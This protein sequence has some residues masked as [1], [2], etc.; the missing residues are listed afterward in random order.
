MFGM[1]M[2]IPMAKD[3]EIDNALMAEARG[4]A[5]ELAG[6]NKELRI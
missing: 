3:V 2:V 4:L 6:W 1:P 5:K